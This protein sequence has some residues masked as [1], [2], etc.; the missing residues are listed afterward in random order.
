[1]M[2]SCTGVRACPILPLYLDPRGGQY[3]TVLTFTNPNLFCG[4]RGGLSGHLAHPCL[5]SHLARRDRPHTAAPKIDPQRHCSNIPCFCF[6]CISWIVDNRPDPRPSPPAL[7]G[8]GGE[9]GVGRAHVQ[10]GS[11]M[12]QR[13]GAPCGVYFPFISGGLQNWGDGMSGAR[14]LGG[15]DANTIA[16]TVCKPGAEP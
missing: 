1:M 10:L 6:L 7:G 4:S 3:T 16:R 2:L 5:L 15:R 12:E 8:G 11:E 9:G 13:G 14:R